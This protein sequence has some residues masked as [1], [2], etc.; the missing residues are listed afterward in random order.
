MKKSIGYFLL[1]NS[2]IF[3]SLVPIVPFLDISN[4]QVI[5]WTTSLIIVGEVS[6]YFAIVLLG[7][8]IWEKIKNFFKKEK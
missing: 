1:I 7:K 2:L 8:E 6:F 4:A 5:A 3:W